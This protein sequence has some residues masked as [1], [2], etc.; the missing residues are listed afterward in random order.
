MKIFIS[1]FLRNVPYCIPTFVPINYMKATFK[2]CRNE[3]V[4]FYERGNI[5]CKFF[6]ASRALKALQTS[7]LLWAI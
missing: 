1:R 3:K 6:I 4:T 2:V 7:S 5:V